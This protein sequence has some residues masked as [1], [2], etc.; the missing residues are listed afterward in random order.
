[1]KKMTPRK[2][3]IQKGDKTYEGGPCK[4]GGHTTRYTS[5]AVCLEC[6]RLSNLSRYSMT[7]KDWMRMYEEQNGI[8]GNPDCDNTSN[9][10]WREQ[11]HNGFCID[12]DHNTGKVRGLL[13]RECNILEGH[14]FKN[15]K[16]TM[17]IIQYKREWDES[18]QKKVTNFSSLL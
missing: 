2:I 13:C 18:Q 15:V 3:A 1:M 17:G 12:H 6:H 8:C 14:I 10:R 7:P 16:K 9:P 4:R 5:T 11:G